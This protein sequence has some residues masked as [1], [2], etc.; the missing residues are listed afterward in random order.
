MKNYGSDLSTFTS[1]TPDLSFKPISGKRAILEA[2]ARRWIT[3]RGT[4]I[5]DRNA[6]TDL[7]MWL[8]G[9]F[10]ATNI[11][12]LQQALADEAQKDERVRSCIVTCTLIDRTLY[13]NGRIEVN[14]DPTPFFFVFQIDSDNVSR[15]QIKEAA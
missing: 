6:G 2:V 5:T 14:D 9:S 7:H 12:I 10:S 3:P 13:V 4:L 15:L 8:N 1:A 11:S